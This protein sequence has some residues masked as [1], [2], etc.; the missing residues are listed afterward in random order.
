MSAVNKDIKLDEP[1]GQG[2]ARSHH[3]SCGCRV[4]GNRKWQSEWKVVCRKAGEELDKHLI[5]W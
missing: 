5:G 2:M 4:V 3:K 1:G